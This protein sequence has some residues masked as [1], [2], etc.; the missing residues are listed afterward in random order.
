[1]LQQHPSAASV[2]LLLPPVA[3]PMAHRGG[4][5]R[6]VRDV[7]PPTPIGVFEEQLAALQASKADMRNL[8][9]HMAGLE[10]EL[11]QLSNENNALRFEQAGPMEDIANLQQPRAVR[12]CFCRR[13][14]LRLQA[15]LGR[16]FTIF[17]GIRSHSEKKGSESR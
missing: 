10:D 11:E 5:S 16:N 3:L 4:S 14:P 7:A 15:S 2:G 8:R 13:A 6:D 9:S 17:G 12:Q 1:M